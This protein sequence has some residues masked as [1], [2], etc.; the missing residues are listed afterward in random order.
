MS[1]LLR[2]WYVFVLAL[3]LS[4]VA[5]MGLLWLRLDDI[6]PAKEVPAADISREA[7]GAGERFREWDFRSAEVEDLRIKLEAR[8][9]QLDARESDLLAW[10]QRIRSEVEELETLKAEIVALREAIN[11]DMVVIEDSQRRNLRNLASMYAEMKPATALRILDEKAAEEVVQVLS[12]MPQDASVRILAAMA[13]S[14]ND[15]ALRRVNE[16]TDLLKQVKHD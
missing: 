2:F 5:A 13:E 8:V 12:L 1:T 10:E 9:Q 3:V 11:E 4:V 7:V 15:E 14:N 6:R 16:I